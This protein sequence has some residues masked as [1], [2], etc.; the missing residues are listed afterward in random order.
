LMLL[1]ETIVPVLAKGTSHSLALYAGG[2]CC[3]VL[4]M[5]SG[6]IP[7]GKKVRNFLP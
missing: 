3:G 1:S 7:Q 5:V 4:V 2:L 6:F